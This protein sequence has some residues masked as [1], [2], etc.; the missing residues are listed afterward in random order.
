MSQ[1]NHWKSTF[2]E[3][4]SNANHRVANHSLDRNAASA[5]CHLLHGKW[6]QDNG[7]TGLHTCYMADLD[8][9]LMVVFTVGV[10]ELDEDYPRKETRGPPA[11]KFE[12]RIQNHYMPRIRALGGDKPDLLLWCK[13]CPVCVSVKSPAC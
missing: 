1:E 13:C 9:Q 5:F 4:A 12:D 7:L 8:F 2:G 11:Y 3:K 6:G 10:L